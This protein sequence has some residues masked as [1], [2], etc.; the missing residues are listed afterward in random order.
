MKRLTITLV[1]VSL[2]ASAVSAHPFIEKH[3]D[4]AILVRLQTGATA[5]QI[6]V[7]VEYRLELLEATVLRDM[8]PFKEEANPFDFRDALKF[9][10]EYT[11][12]YAP[13]LADRFVAEANAKQIAE[14]R[15]LSHKERL[16]DENGKGLGYLRCDFVFESAFQTSDS[17]KTRFVFQE[18]NFILEPG[19]IELRLVNETGLAAE[20]ATGP[21]EGLLK[22]AK[23]NADLEN[24]D[25]LREVAIVLAPRNRSTNPPPPEAKAPP[26]AKDPP[27]AGTTDDSGAL[28]SHDDTFSLRRLIQEKNYG[29]W[30]I[31]I[32]AFFFGA[33]H[34][35]TP[36]HGKTLVAAYLVG[37]RGTVWHALFLGLVTTLTHTGMV[38]LLAAIMTVLP[39]DAQKS[40]ETWI[41]NGLGLVL[42]L[43]IVSMGFW[44]LLQ[45]LS[46]K[47]D[48][49]HIGGGH[50]HHHDDTAPAVP[51]A[52]D[53]SWWGL[54]MLGVTG[55]MVPC[56]DAVLLLFYAVGTSHMWIVL[57]SLLAFS[58][59]LA[60]VLVLIGILVVQVPRFVQARSGDSRL[61]RALPTV[62]AV[63]VI[64]VGLW[65]CYEWSQTR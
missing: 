23:E 20:S 53:L 35:L 1:V 14:F 31:L 2:F 3:H 33:A 7:R 9:Y 56:G 38:L 13:I 52:R 58:A 46:G 4:R 28:R 51:A 45:R 49:F 64:L 29:F 32:L 59:G 16:E 22:R 25:R 12:I 30:L 50:H 47:A 37:E 40:F 41:E 6:R 63:A 48:H 36:G 62:S 42:G 65:L 11:R 18:K 39:E 10:A 61:V 57:P 34:A 44:L 19:Y 43:I 17:D 27:A 21:D 15:C 55:G 54:V 8:K 26:Q 60:G 24:D 5:G